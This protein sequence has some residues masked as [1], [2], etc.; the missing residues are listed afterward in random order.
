MSF[1]FSKNIIKCQLSGKR[2]LKKVLSLGFL[3][4]VNNYFSTGI[5]KKEEVFFQQ[6]YFILKV[7]S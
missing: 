2:D 7:L 1:R 5:R 6:K 3:P 4:P